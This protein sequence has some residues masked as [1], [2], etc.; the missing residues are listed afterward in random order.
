MI[1]KAQRW[2]WRMPSSTDIDLMSSSIDRF[3]SLRN[4]WWRRNA[5]VPARRPPRPRSFLFPNEPFRLEAQRQAVITP[6]G[7][8]TYLSPPSSFSC[9]RDTFVL[10]SKRKTGRV[11]LEGGIVKIKKTECYQPIS[12][13]PSLYVGATIC[14]FNCSAVTQSLSSIQWLPSERKNLETNVFWKC[15]FQTFLWLTEKANSEIILYTK[16]SFI[17]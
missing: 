11:S 16:F 9:L 17:C 8:L 12:S 1:M 13:S 3:W 15:F 10:A 2:S 5:T 7:S 4:K 6:V 14:L